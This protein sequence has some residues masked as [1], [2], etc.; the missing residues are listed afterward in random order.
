[1]ETERASITLWPARRLCPCPVAPPLVHAT[2]QPL[3]ECLQL[4][5]SDDDPFCRWD[6]AQRLARQVLLRAEHQPKPGVEAA[7]IQALNQ[8]ISSYDGG[9]GMD[10]AALLALPGMAELE[11]LQAPVDPLALDR[12]FREWTQELGIQLQSSLRRSWSWPGPTGP[13]LGQLARAAVPT[14]LAGVGWEQR[15]TPGFKRTLW[16]RFLALR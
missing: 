3:E 9:D 8:R 10:L 11:A 13:W 15:V 6:A 14:A 16:Q 1:M 4:L 2:E 5:A 12:A 7:L